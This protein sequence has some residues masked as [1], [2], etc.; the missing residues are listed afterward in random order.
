MSGQRCPIDHREMETRAGRL[1]RPVR[2]ALYLALGF[3]SVIMGVIGIAI[4]VWPTTC[5]LLLAGWCFAR[6]SRRAERWLFG[7][8]I[9]GRYLTAYKLRGT[10]S[11]RVRG[12]SL[13]GLWGS[14]AAST[15]FVFDQL[16]L[17][18]LLVIVASAVS[19][20]LLSLRTE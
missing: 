14:I 12:A 5:F 4:P 7:N 16:W 17:V 13:V 1:P 2:K 20:H 19:A 15:Y 6:S 8:P 18:A 10:I 3:V 11:S 9:F